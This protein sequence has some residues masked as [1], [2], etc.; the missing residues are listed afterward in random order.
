MEFLD[1]W[2]CIAISCGSKGQGIDVRFQ[3]GVKNISLFSNVQ[4]VSGT[5]GAYHSKGT[6]VKSPERKDNWTLYRSEVKNT[7]RFYSFSH[8]SMLHEAWLLK[9]LNINFYSESLSFCTLSI[10]RIQRFRLAL[11]K[12]PN[13][14]GFFFPSPQD[15]NISSFRNVVSSSVVHYR[16]NPFHSTL[17]FT[18]NFEHKAASVIIESRCSNKIW[19]WSTLV[20]PIFKI[21][22]LQLINHY[23]DQVCDTIGKGLR[24]RLISWNFLLEAG[25]S[26]FQIPCRHWIF[27]CI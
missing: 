12:G 3:T 9:H 23:S 25:R 8:S 16:Q 21:C 18:F 14:I 10:V 17:T 7:W 11:F 6:E 15:E 26:R 1:T 24:R 27:Q 19:I 5:H 20:T 13:R 4:I 2:V 22:P